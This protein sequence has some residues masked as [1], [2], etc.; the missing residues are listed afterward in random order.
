MGFLSPASSDVASLAWERRE[1]GLYLSKT[2]TESP[3]PAALGPEK[4]TGL[5]PSGQRPESHT[6]SWNWG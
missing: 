5:L 4:N 6:L 3:E 2:W 1:M